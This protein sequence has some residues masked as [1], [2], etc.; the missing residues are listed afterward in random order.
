MF[1]VKVKRKLVVDG[2]E[3]S[4]LMLIWLRSFES[5]SV[6]FR[7]LA[8]CRMSMFGVFA[9]RH[10][11]KAA[12]D[13]VPR[14]SSFGKDLEDVVIHLVER[15]TTLLIATTLTIDYLSTT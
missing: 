4:M 6:Y 14:G 2:L 15:V 8:A 5:F 11:C 7:L 10:G 12:A 3:E 13:D 1:S 9:S